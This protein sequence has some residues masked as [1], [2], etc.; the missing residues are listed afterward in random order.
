MLRIHTGLRKWIY[1]NE[2]D[3]N[4]KNNPFDICVPCIKISND[5]LLFEKY[6][7]ALNWENMTLGFKMIMQ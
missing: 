5:E 1:A 3:P 7:M 6:R 4:L 2:F